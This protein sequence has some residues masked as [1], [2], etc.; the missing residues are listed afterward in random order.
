MIGKTALINMRV[1]SIGIFVTDIVITLNKLPSP[2][3]MNYVTKNE[4]GEI[5]KSVGGHA[6]IFATDIAKLGL[7]SKEVGAVGA[8]G[9]DENGRF[10]NKSLK[11]IGVRTFL[12]KK[13]VAT[14]ENII[15]AI[16]GEDK[17]Y[18]LYPGANLELE[19]DF[20]IESV[21]EETPEIVYCCAGY[22]G[23]D[24]NLEDIFKR[25]KK[26]IGSYIFLDIVDPYKKGKKFFFPALKHVDALKANQQETINSTGKSNMPEASK[27]LLD[28]GV[29]SMFITRGPKGAEYRTKD[30][31]VSQPPFVVDSVDQTGCG[32]AFTA[33]ITYKI[34]QE[35]KNPTELDPDELSAVLAYGQAT[36]AIAA[37]EGGATTAV[38]K[39][40]VNNL[41]ESQGKEVIENSE[42]ELL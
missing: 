10:L 39:E 5:R 2:G 22:T 12:Q 33:G 38:S 14:S 23:I 34:L 16:K 32:D 17:R 41:M 30:M 11:D 6:A 1:M 36:G 18:D 15:L 26:E 7:N 21:L 27:A 29:G 20:V 28:Q 4:H 42:K 8:I 19:K 35:K 37:T 24:L 9:K 25:V 3:V 13:D 40:N 31:K